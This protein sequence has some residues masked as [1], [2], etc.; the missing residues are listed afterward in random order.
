L[1]ATVTRL[2]VSPGLQP[3]L[4]R[5]SAHGGRREFPRSRV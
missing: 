1:P 4:F 5:R 3:H 2:Q